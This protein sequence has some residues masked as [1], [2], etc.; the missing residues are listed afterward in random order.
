MKNNYADVRLWDY[1]NNSFRR[2]GLQFCGLIMAD[3]AKCGINTMFNTG[4][5]VGV[6][7]NI[8][9]SGFPRNFVPDFAWG[10]NHGFEVYS[11]EKMFETAE[12]VFERRN[13]SFTD[14][15]KRILIR[16]FELTERYRNTPKTN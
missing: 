14:I 16:V 12:K 3:H 4:T 1:P 7:A 5:V 8:F 15:E 9:G 2:T 11:L 6:S 10:G 13:Q